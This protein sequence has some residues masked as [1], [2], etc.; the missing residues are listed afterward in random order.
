MAI[1]KEK[2]AWSDEA[3]KALDRA[4]GC[5]L[6]EIKRQVDQGRCELWRYFDGGYCV[7]RVEVSLVGTCEL[8]LVA[9]GVTGGAEKLADWLGFAS[10]R[11]WTVRAHSER[12]GSKKFLMKQGFEVSEIVYRWKNGKSVISKE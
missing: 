11:G 9:S 1:K 8:V 3:A 6:Q 2:V 5:D 7:T 10:Q 12:R 4:L